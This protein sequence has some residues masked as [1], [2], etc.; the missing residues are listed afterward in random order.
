MAEG[1]EVGGGWDRR[2]FRGGRGGGRVM[3]TGRTI[4]WTRALG[5]GM[6]MVEGGWER[7]ACLEM[8][9]VRVFVFLPG[10]DVFVGGVGVGGCSGDVDGGD[11]GDGGGDVEVVFFGW[12]LV[13]VVLLLMLLFL[14]LLS[15][16]SPHRLKHFFLTVF[17][18]KMTT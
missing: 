17:R 12:L 9:Q 7:F 8:H 10:L 15:L 13:V 6:G 5:G 4:A 1:V 16:L 3:C 18:R 11:G 2:R 14:F